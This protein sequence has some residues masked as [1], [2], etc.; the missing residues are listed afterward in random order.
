MAEGVLVSLLVKQVEQDGPGLE[1][2]PK[3]PLVRACPVVQVGPGHARSGHEQARDL[4]Q[5]AMTRERGKM[6]KTIRLERNKQT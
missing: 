1:A 4:T 2:G 5:V 3:Q 6:K